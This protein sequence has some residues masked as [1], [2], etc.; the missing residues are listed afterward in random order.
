MNLNGLIS[1]SVI[2]NAHHRL[3]YIWMT[4]LL[5]EKYVLFTMK[6]MDFYVL[7]YHNLVLIAETNAAQTSKYISTVLS[8]PLLPVYI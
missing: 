1:N 8:E 7:S 6:K 5:L 3:F 2:L 4:S